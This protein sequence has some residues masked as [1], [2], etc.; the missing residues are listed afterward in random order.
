MGELFYLFTLDVWDNFLPQAITF[1]RGCSSIFLPG[2][3][4]AERFPRISG[5]SCDRHDFSGALLYEGLVS[6]RKLS[7]VCKE[8]MLAIYAS[9]IPSSK[10]E[11]G[12]SG[13][14]RHN[15]ASCGSPSCT[16]SWSMA[17]CPL[18]LHMQKSA[19]PRQAHTSCFLS[20]MSILG[21]PVWSFI[22]G[23]WP[24]PFCTA[25]LC[26]PFAMLG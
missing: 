3:P 10:R 24:L 7:F 23:Q 22:R 4:D 20:G 25:A 16:F 12:R 18:L 19:S 26:A 5:D 2:L 21:Q 14:E 1:L 13:R 15:P 8:D 6:T 17:I 9:D 11:P